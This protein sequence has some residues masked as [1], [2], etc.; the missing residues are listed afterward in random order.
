MNSNKQGFTLIELLVVI[1][2]IALLV[3]ILLPALNRARSQARSTV[4]L[5]NTRQ[6]GIGTMMFASENK[7]KYPWEGEKE[8][9]KKN[10]E[11]KDW[12]ANAAPKMLGEK[13][14]RDI[15]EY[16][17]SNGRDI[18]VPPATGNIFLCPAAKPDSNF[19][20][21]SDTYFFDMDSSYEGKFFTCYN[22]NS[23][24][25]NGLD[26]I[27][28]T[29]DDLRNVV[30]SRLKRS[31]ETIIMLEMRISNEEL[32]DDD[33]EYYRTRPLYRRHRSD[34]KR[35]S[36]RH[37]GGS[38]AVFA[39]GHSSRLDYMEVTTSVEGHRDPDAYE[40]D[41]WNKPG[42]IWNPFGPSHK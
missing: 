36:R 33:V 26:G 28:E 23:E 29:A 27:G 17:I 37:Y 25:N 11:A 2:I 14:C 22:W 5:S 20:P 41:N 34:W 19:D 4:C 10:F 24:L 13:S 6:W 18:P 1:T 21:D 32:E 16:A 15:S 35:I 9:C 42:M 39:D 40:M 38:S 31:S 8:L 7:D 30:A 12:W 3:S